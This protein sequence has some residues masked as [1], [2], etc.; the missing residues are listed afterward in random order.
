MTSAESWPPP[1]PPPNTSHKPIG[2]KI[3]CLV[4]VAGVLL[5]L[6]PLL[7]LAAA[8]PFVDLDGMNEGNSSLAALPWL[9]YFS[10]PLGVII[11]VVGLVIWL[12]AMMAKK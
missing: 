1:P 9:L 3:G 7:F 4:S 10:V 11:V 8:L 2:R 12:V 5:A 6:S